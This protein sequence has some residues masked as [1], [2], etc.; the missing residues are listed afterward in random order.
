MTDG[1]KQ[2][3][4]PE[5]LVDAA[6]F[7]PLGLAL[8]ARRLYPELVARGRRQLLFTRTVGK[9]AVR[10]GQHRLDDLVATGVGLVGGFLP[11]GDDGAAPVSEE[12]AVPASDPDLVAVPDEPAAPAIDDAHLAIPD[13][14]SLSAFQV[15]PRLEALD[16]ADLDAVRLYEESTRGRRTILNKIAQLS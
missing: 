16:P 4:V 10:R 12:V 3:S 15:M 13:Y 11:G 5:Q 9:F 14:D 8:E 2:R 6:L 1:Q 7:A